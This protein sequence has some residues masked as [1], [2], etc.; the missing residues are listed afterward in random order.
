MSMVRANR[1]F[2]TLSQ[3][4]AALRAE[5]QDL[6]QEAR[7]FREEPRMIE[8]LARRDLGLIEPGEVLFI[9]TN[10]TAATPASPD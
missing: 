3:V 7:E 8:H 5:N 10:V 6:R 2:N 4:I 9:V 1:E